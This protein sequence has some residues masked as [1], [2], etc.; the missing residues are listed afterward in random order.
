[1]RL[2]QE[3]P[4]S[5]FPAILAIVVALGAVLLVVTVLIRATR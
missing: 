5:K 4:G 2:G 3:L 1:L